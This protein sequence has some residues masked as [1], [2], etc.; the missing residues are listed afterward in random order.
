MNNENVQIIVEDRVVHDFGIPTKKWVLWHVTGRCNIECPYCYGSFNGGSYKSDFSRADDIPLNTLVAAA[1]DIASLGFEYVHINGGEPLLRSDIV[2]FLSELRRIGLKVWLLTNGTTQLSKLSNIIKNNLVDL[3]A[4][5]ID[6]K[7]AETI[8]LQRER[9]ESVIKNTTRIVHFRN[10]YRSKVKLG[11]YCVATKLNLGKIPDLVDYLIELGFDY[12]NVQPMYLPVGH[13]FGKNNIER[14]HL[15]QVEAYIDHMRKNADKIQVSTEAN[16]SL[17]KFGLNVDQSKLTAKNCFARD[18]RYLYIGPTG[19]VH[20]C[21]AIPPKHNKLIGN[22]VQGRLSEFY[23][24]MDRSGGG[25]CEFLSL[26][27]LGMYE[28][29]YQND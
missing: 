4:I 25:R 29:V 28:M 21:P 24:T 22:I 17:T 19:N 11:A 26:D 14:I 2:E 16:F 27:C 1:E 6:A 15:A 13:F 10:E 7:D 12:L 23:S 3:L 20:G 18:G 5:S 9:G 8:N